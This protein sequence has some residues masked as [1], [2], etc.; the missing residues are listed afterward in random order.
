MILDG[1]RILLK[2]KLNNMCDAD[3]RSANDAQRTMIVLIYHNM[4]WVSIWVLPA[5]NVFFRQ[6]KTHCALSPYRMRIAEII[7]IVCALKA[8]L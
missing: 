6:M 5:N 8:R 7:R 2:H 3:N 1:S 4:L